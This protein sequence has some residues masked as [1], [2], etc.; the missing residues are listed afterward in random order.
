MYKRAIFSLVAITVFFTIAVFA[1]AS[2][3]ISHP[4][5]EILDKSI[6]KGSYE[7][8]SYRSKLPRETISN[9]YRE[10]LSRQ[11]W[12]ETFL[13]DPYS[14]D[15]FYFSK[16]NA[17]L[18]LNFNPSTDPNLVYYD[19][20]VDYL[21]FITKRE[22][23]IFRKVSLPQRLDFIPTYPGSE[24]IEVEKSSREISA[25]Y[26]A[27]GSPENVKNFY[28]KEM[29]ALGWELIDQ[30]PIDGDTF[31]DREKL[32]SDP[33]LSSQIENSIEDIRTTGTILMF[34]KTK[35]SC[36]VTVSQ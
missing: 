33:Y 17:R 12:E 1:Q 21:N 16:D 23:N 13:S 22:E 20:K 30:G 19:I 14:T 28:I 8:Y 4:N 27:S 3:I 2:G 7:I 35:K 11:G 10:M 34:G 6:E 9:F 18:S 25:V 24:Q 15:L 36:F 32:L 31:P 5:S 29:P 26:L